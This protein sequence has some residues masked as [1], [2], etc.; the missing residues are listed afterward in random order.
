MKAGFERLD[1]KL[2]R[3]E[4][5]VEKIAEAASDGLPVG[6]KTAKPIIGIG[7]LILNK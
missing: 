4:N 6:N 7:C 5:I 3:I 2:G 1:I